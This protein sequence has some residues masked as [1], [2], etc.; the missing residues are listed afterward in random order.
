MN[1][2]EAEDNRLMAIIEELNG[3]GLPQD[4]VKRCMDELVIMTMSDGFGKGDI[5]DDFL[6]I[7]KRLNGSIANKN[8]INSML[9]YCLG[10]TSKS[11][12]GDLSNFLPV[13]RIFARAGFPDI[14]ADF[15]HE[16]RQEVYDYIIN[17]Y[18]REYVGNI[19]TYQTLKMRSYV[20]RAAKALDIADA[21]HKGKDEYVSRNNEFVRRM[22][23]SLPE[24]RG[25]ILKVQD[26]E[27]EEHEI[28]TVKDAYEHCSEFSQW[29]EKYP[30]ILKHS[31]LIE[32]LCSSYGVHAAGI[33]ISKIPL[34]EI[35]PLR[36]TGKNEDEHGVSFATQFAYEDLESL[37]LIKF[38]ILSVSTLSVISECLKL[39]E[40]RH[41]LKIDIENLP[42]DDHE[43]FKLYRTGELAGVFQCEERGMQKTMVQMNVDSY[44]DICA[45]IALF[46]PGPMA[47]IPKYCARKK[48]NERI[49]YM[50]PSL[51]PLLKRWLDKTYGILVYQEQVMQICN[52][53]AN[54]SIAD[55]YQVIKAVGKKKFDLLKKFRSRFV[56]GAEQNSVPTN[57]AEKFWDDFIM[58]FAQYGFNASHSACYGLI[59]YQTA[60]LKAHF[61]NEFICSYLNVE[62]KKKDWDRVA[63]LEKEANRIGISIAN[64]NINTA[65]MNYT[66]RTVSHPIHG[67]SH[68]L[69]PPIV[70]KGMRV[71]AAEDIVSKAPFKSFEDLCNRVDTSVVDTEAIE[72]LRL[73]GFF[74]IT[75]NPV[76][77]FIALRDSIK[78]TRKKGF[79]STDMFG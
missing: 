46:R 11:P 26:D 36:G 51:E 78:K 79:A 7:R 10:M 30:E 57:V 32:G 37:G 31:S 48:G 60:Y 5:L 3:K 29:V 61:P 77:K 45:G 33:V 28:K 14:D 15:D 34:S 18:G 69:I 68:T 25:A 22:I 38:D 63:L 56:K 39:I 6:D 21:F 9:A 55:G 53:V 67:E 35:A 43:T 1:K 62:M 47:S 58:P 64:R 16:R 17:K 23:D 27:G 4:V 24:Q 65:S 2:S 42:L 12:D 54:F 19:G 73:A 41:G 20:T 49:D 59:S 71:S 76:E 13:R 8:D 66:L 75:N 70:C 72:A 40:S 44:K 52:S 50:H 74:K